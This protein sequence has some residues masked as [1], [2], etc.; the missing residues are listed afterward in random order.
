MFS[1]SNLFINISEIFFFS[2]VTDVLDGAMVTLAIY[3]LNFAH[4]GFLLAEPQTK[5]VSDYPL[6]TGDSER[7]F[8]GSPASEVV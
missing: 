6:S 1:P 8:P 2:F 4:P 3:T 5:A 7:K